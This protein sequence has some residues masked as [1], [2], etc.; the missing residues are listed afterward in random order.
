MPVEDN[1]FLLL[2]TAAGQI[3]LLH[4]S[5]TE[6]KNLFSFEI[7]GRDGKLEITGLGGSY[8]IERL[9][10]YKMRPEM[11]PPETTIWEYPDGRQFLGSRV[12]RIPG[13]HPA[14]APA[15][16][17]HRRR[18]GR[19]AHRRAR[20]PGE[21]ADDHHPQP[22]AHLARRRRH[23]PAVLLPRAQ[24][25]RDLGRHRQVRLHHAARDLQPGT[26]HQVFEDGTGGDASTR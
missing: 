6:W 12:R 21:R 14:A 19:L 11:G 18:A 16:A 3:A 20:V 24:R 10:F 8:G 15:A 25:I 9:T 1:A 23:R 2:E 7:Y 22:A 13:G 4:A 5:W 26:A 17:G